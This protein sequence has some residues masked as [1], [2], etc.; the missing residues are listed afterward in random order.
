VKTLLRRG[1][2]AGAAAVVIAGLVAGPTAPASAAGAVSVTVTSSPASVSTSHAMA[3]TITVANTGGADASGLTITDTF[4]TLSPGN[5]ETTP[6]TTTSAGTCSWDPTATKLT[7][8]AAS[9]PAGQAW[10]VTATGL[11]TAAAGTAVSDTATVTG[12]ESGAAFSVAG[13]VTT[14]VTGGLPAGF[15]QTTLAHGLSKPVVIAFPPGG[16]IWIGEQGGTILDDHNGAIQPTPVVTLPNVFSQGETGLLGLA[17]DPNFA[18]NGYVYISYTANV[19]NKSGVTQ[20]LA[21]LSRF[22]ASGGTINPAT[23]KVYAQGNQIQNLHH[24]AN[25]VKIGPDGKLWW[26]VGDNVPSISNAQALSNIY[27]KILRYNLD[28]SIPADNPY[29]NIAGGVPAIYATGVRNPFRFTFLPNGQPFMENTGSPGVADAW[30]DLYGIHPGD[31]YGWPYY[32]GYC[33]SCG[34]INPTFQYGHIPNDG[35]ASAI[36]AYSGTTFPQ[37]YDHTVFVGDYNRRDIQAVGFDPT[38]QTPTSDTVFA[39]N[40]GTIADLEQGPDGNL[41]FV[42][43]FEGTFSEIS[44]PGPFPPTAAASATPSAGTGP[45]TVQFSSAGSSD[46]FGQPL[47]YSWDFGDGSAPSASANPSYTYTASG[48]YTATLT[49]S[50]GTQT[51]SSSTTVVVGQVPPTASITA[52]ATYNAGSTVSF[53]GSATD[54]VDSSVPAYDYA[55]KVDFYRGGVIDPSYYGEVAQPSYGPVSGI[56]SGSFQIP[57]DP[58]QTPDSFYRITLT[59]TDSRGLQTV[60]TKDIH[61]NLTSFTVNTDVPGTGFYVDGTWHPSSY[62][63]QDVV[64]AQHVLIGMALPQVIGGTRYRFIG[65]ADGSALTD[66]FTSG[67]SPAT[68]TANYDPVQTA[69]PTGWQSTDIGAPIT[70]GTADYSSSSQSFYLDGAG[71]DEYGKND[72]SHFVYQTLSGDGSI[73]ARIRYQTNSDPWAKAGVMIRQSTATGAP[74]VDALVTGDVSPNTPN[75]NGIG[76]N[77][78]GCLSPLPAIVPPVGNGVREQTSGSHSSTGPNLTGFTSPSKWLKLTKAGSTFTAYESTDGAGWT[79]IGVQ[80][81][82]MTGPVDIG[83]F[84]TGHD[85]GQVSSVAF[86]NVQV[87]GSTPPPPPG[88]LPSPWTD[89]DVGSPAIAGSAGYS[90]GVFTVNGAGAD[91]YGTNDQFHYAYQPLAGNGNGTLIARLTSMSN[92]SSNAKAGIMIKQSTTAGSAYLLISSGPAGNIK[93]QYGFNASTGGGT[94]TFPNV[95]MKL[96]SLNGQITAY[97]S[98]DG[99]TWASVASKALTLTSPATIGLF[100][101]SHN[102][103]ALGTAT[104]DNVSFTPGP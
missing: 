54:P 85:I 81:V 65:W 14:T 84:D 26:S 96:V 7:C 104:F 86:D 13:A 75:I 71:A 76:C 59:V 24:A 4:P 18:S 23:E 88:P 42:S 16:D 40:A 103:S 80:T 94:F 36:A 45:L 39:T 49:V 28:G 53:S 43:I 69:M 31:N 79:Q 33:G 17:L 1:A 89:T 66:S 8:T 47:S 35:A 25:T 51:A 93:V 102:V 44:A 90:N 30:E 6:A 34:Y 10:T 83:L 20:A 9:L 61:P 21:R 95:W 22:T 72:Q 97:V 82:A 46:A 92:T 101:C 52:P 48:T 77:A 3:Y 41:Y 87:T 55:W 91:I 12:T 5:G 99:V 11:Q 15:V 57:A 32:S 50:N 38:Y 19:T 27:G 60:V 67:A 56:T 2:Q 70:A 63:A 78:S 98:G 73:I 58:Y 62:T 37:A 64:G 74:F 29:V 68:Y 100:E